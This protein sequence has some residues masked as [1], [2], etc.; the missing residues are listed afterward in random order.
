[1]TGRER[2]GSGSVGKVLPTQ[3]P[4]C[5]YNPCTTRV[6]SIASRKTPS[7][8]VWHTWIRTD[9]PG[10]VRVVIRALERQR[11]ELFHGGQEHGSPQ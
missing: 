10:V 6:L 7:V 9:G 8:D 11:P 5:P 2:W 3:G 1:M 4:F